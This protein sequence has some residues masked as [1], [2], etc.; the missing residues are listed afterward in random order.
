MLAVDLIKREL[1]SIQERTHASHKLTIDIQV[2]LNKA[3]SSCHVMLVSTNER[4]VLVSTDQSKAGKFATC[5]ALNHGVQI[6]IA[7]HL[8][9]Y[10]E[11]AG[12]FQSSVC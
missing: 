1:Q 11:A 3:S 9:Q 2:K 4:S 10:L 6:I 12:E 5:S 7:S 8:L